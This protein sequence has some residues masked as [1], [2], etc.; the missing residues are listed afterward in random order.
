VGKRERG[1]YTPS[2]GRTG[3][4]E[5][6]VWGH[7]TIRPNGRSWRA[8][9]KQKNRTHAF[10]GEKNGKGG[11]RGNEQV[12]QTPKK[13]TH[14]GPDPKNL[15]RTHYNNPTTMIHHTNQTRV[16][17]PLKMGGKNTHK[18]AGDTVTHTHQICTKTDGKRTPGEPDS[19]VHHEHIVD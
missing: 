17:R 15:N 6:T 7:K 1:Q 13:Q 11:K 12:T 10:Q 2:R 14:R 16:M 9:T 19:P 8:K 3:K 18:G 5:G 4:G